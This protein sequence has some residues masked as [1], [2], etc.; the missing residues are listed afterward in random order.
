MEI[1]KHLQNIKNPNETVIIEN[2]F[3]LKDIIGSDKFSFYSYEGSLTTPP[4][5]QNV[6]WIVSKT[7]LRLQQSDV[8]IF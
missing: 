8:N 5:T 1:A 3:P 7:T 4:C 6:I 2:K